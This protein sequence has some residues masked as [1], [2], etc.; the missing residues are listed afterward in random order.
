M[1]ALVARRCTEHA[2]AW[3]A[4]GRALE[5]EDLQLTATTL[6]QLKTELKNVASILEAA[7]KEL[8]RRKQ[9]AAEQER[10][11]QEI[12][13][14]V[15][16]VKRDVGVLGDAIFGGLSMQVQ[17]E[18]VGTIISGLV[19]E[20][21]RETARRAL[22]TAVNPPNG[23]LPSGPALRSAIELA[24]AAQVPENELADAIAALEAEKQRLYARQA[25]SRALTPNP[26]ERSVQAIG[27]ALQ[28]AKAAG[29][30][31]GELQAAEEALRSGQKSSIWYDIISILAD[32]STEG[33]QPLGSVLSGLVA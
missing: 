26:E 9:Y 13:Q 10:A 1:P 12:E 8:D 23:E 28:T 22:V 7:G 33:Q 25:L 19:E 11:R 5:G 6:Q 31:E 17:T 21:R 4:V 32:D 3:F 2:Q 29:V 16:T 15:A 30:D 20:E 18:D 27:E 24:L 14:A